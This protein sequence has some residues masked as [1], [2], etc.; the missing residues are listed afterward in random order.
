[1]VESNINI[2]SYSHVAGI[3]LVQHDLGLV[4]RIT[5]AVLNQ[6]NTCNMGVVADVESNIN[7]SNKSH[8]AGITL[9]Q[10]DL[11]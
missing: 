6:S 5:E 3:T 11:G 7:I 8:V 1:D 9:V 4:G 10:H 2:S